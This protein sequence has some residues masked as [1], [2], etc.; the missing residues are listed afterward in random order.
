[1][2]FECD[3]IV[4]LTTLL[5]N[6]FWKFS[7]GIIFSKLSLPKKLKYINKFSDVAVRNKTQLTFQNDGY[8]HGTESLTFRI[9]VGFT[10][11]SICDGDFH[12]IYFR[13]KTDENGWEN[14][15]FTEC[16]FEINRQRGR[17]RSINFSPPLPGLPWEVMHP[18]DETSP[19]YQ[20]TR[21]QIELENGEIIAIL[22][23]IDEISSLNYQSR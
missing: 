20:L 7:G 16:E 21:E 22:D 17:N 8:Q 5:A 11:S 15:E 9:A 1:M 13:T 14:F 12:L 23:G 4:L 18:I 19:L 6:F 2:T 10:N 3:M